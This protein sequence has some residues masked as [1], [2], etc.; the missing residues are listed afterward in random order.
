MVGS[1]HGDGDASRVI[2]VRPLLARWLFQLIV[3][4]GLGAR[5]GQEVLD[6]MQEMNRQ[7]FLAMADFPAFSICPALT[8]RKRWAGYLALRERRSEML[9]PLIRA[10]R[11]APCYAASLLE[12]RL[13]DEGG[14]LLTDSEI[15][16]LCSEFMVGATDTSVTMM[17]W[18]M[19]GGAGEPPRCSSQ[20][21]RGG[22]GQA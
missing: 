4:T 8:M 21:V 3:E 12:L 15:V 18:I 10:S 16:S 1:L 7:V 14:R 19:H 6:E 5:L 13:D 2:T 20:G 17:E 22:E 11:G 9:L